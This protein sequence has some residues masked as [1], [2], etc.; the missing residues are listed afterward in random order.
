MRLLIAY[1]FPGKEEVNAM[2]KLVTESL[3]GPYK[4]YL[5]QARF[6]MARTV[7]IICYFDQS[8]NDLGDIGLLI[9]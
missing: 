7:E 3:K 2:Q 1:A 9:Q 6:G 8:I 5:T 4:A